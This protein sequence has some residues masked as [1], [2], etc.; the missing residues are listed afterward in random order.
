[1]VPC[2]REV[3]IAAWEQIIAFIFRVDELYVGVSE[4][5]VGFYQFMTPYPESP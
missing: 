2:S 5:F 1:M 4:E 3:G